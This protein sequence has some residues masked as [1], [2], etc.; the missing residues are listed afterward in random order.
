MNDGMQQL[1]GF[2]ILLVSQRPTID[3]VSVGHNLLA[4]RKTFHFRIV[5]R[6][7]DIEEGLGSYLREAQG[8]AAIFH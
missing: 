8:N 4:T 2:T 6:I 1:D 3:D 7:N 5:H